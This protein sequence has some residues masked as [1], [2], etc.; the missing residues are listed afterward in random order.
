MKGYL[1]KDPRTNQV[2][3][4]TEGEE[5]SLI[6]TEYRPVCVYSDSTLL[7]VRLITGRPHQI[8]AHLA[9]LGHPVIGDPKYGVRAV[10]EQ[11]RKRYGVRYQL[12]HACRLELPELEAPF[13]AVSGK[14]FHAEL[15][16]L[17]QAVIKEKERE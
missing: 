7:E 3:I 9:S 4:R 6:E 14:V 12:L 5:G 17:M 1:K 11:Y 13:E 15:P 2:R 10:N 8:R 16:A